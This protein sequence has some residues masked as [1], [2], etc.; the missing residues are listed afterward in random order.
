MLDIILTS[1]KTVNKLKRK[2]DFVFKLH[3][4]LLEAVN[5]TVDLTVFVYCLLYSDC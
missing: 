4:L 3:Q 5:K 1:V 2:S